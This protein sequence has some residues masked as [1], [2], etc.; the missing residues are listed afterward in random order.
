[1][2]IHLHLVILKGKFQKPEKNI[3]KIELLLFELDF[4][5]IDNENYIWRKKIDSQQIQEICMFY[6]TLEM[7][8]QGNDFLK[9]LTIEQHRCSEAIL[10]L[11]VSKMFKRVRMGFNFNWKI[12]QKQNSFSNSHHVKYNANY[13]YSFY[14]N[15]GKKRRAGS[16]FYFRRRRHWRANQKVRRRSR[17]RRGEIY[18]RA[19][20]FV[21]SFVLCRQLT[22]LAATIS[23]RWRCSTFH[24][25]VQP[26][27]RN[28][29][30]QSSFYANIKKS[31][32]VI[33]R[34]AKK[35]TNN[36]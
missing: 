11:A 30:K 33:E 26:F 5:F 14:V 36:I 12:V 17:D 23:A 34:T 27:Q 24:F 6:F 4:I 29:E 20:A 32:I 28:L 21:G 1:M 10:I 35:T 19:V 25:L 13:A 16:A 15:K 31:T 9:L 3:W 2:N 22:V 7:I 18:D 8:Y